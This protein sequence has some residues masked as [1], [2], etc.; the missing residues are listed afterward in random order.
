[1]IR[2]NPLSLSNSGRLHKKK[3]YLYIHYHDSDAIKLIMAFNARRFARHKRPYPVLV[4][5]ERERK[6]LERIKTRVI[7][8]K[9]MRSKRKMVDAREVTEQEPVFYYY[10]YHQ[11]EAYHSMTEKDRLD[12]LNTPEYANIIKLDSLYQDMNLYKA[13]E[14]TEIIAGKLSTLGANDKL[15]ILGHGRA[16]MP[17]VTSELDDANLIPTR[18]LVLRLKDAGLSKAILD[19]RLDTCESADPVSL[20]SFSDLTSPLHNLKK[21][22]SGKTSAAQTLSEALT[23]AGYPNVTV[24]GYHGSGLVLYRVGHEPHRETAVRSCDNL[25]RLRV[26]TAKR[27]STLRQTFRGGQKLL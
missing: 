4:E 7:L 5:S 18:E 6:A 27:A 8:G 12:L 26:E 16:G 15:Y 3:G 10:L 1:M 23:Y 24:T 21:F 11:G 14:Q 20:V 9:E 2:N 17:I 22:F 25:Q 13:F 19:I